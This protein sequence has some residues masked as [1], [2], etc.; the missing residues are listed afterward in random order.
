MQLTFLQ[1]SVGNL[2]SMSHCR[3]PRVL[4]KS[5]RLVLRLVRD[6]FHTYLHVN[7]LPW[8]LFDFHYFLEF[9]S[10]L[11]SIIIFTSYICLYCTKH[12]ILYCCLKTPCSI[13]HIYILY[14]VIYCTITVLRL[15]TAFWQ[16][17][18][19][20]FTSG[21]ILSISNIYPLG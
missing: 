1:H 3:C 6:I 5:F 4:Q 12:F 19:L 11:I 8:I 16:K 9:Y 17:I 2:T 20:S 21:N 10:I 13:G 18:V 14:G 15:N 7:S